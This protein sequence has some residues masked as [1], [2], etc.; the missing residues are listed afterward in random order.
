MSPTVP[1]RAQSGFSII[2]LIVALVLAASLFAALLLWFARPLEA[3]L[4]SQRQAAAAD[5]AERAMARFSAEIAGALPNSVRVACAGRCLELIPVVDAADYRVAS[6]GNTLDFGSADGEFDVLMPLSAAPA[7]G[8]Q[9]V[10]NNLN[11]GSTGNLSAYSA[12]ADNNRSS[13]VAGGSAAQIHIA[14]KQ[15]P[16]PSPT[17]RF[18]IVATPV[19]YVCDPA[20]SGGT[21]RRYAG[22]AI[23]PNQPVDTSLGD[24]LA[25]GVV[26]CRFDVV[27]E[28]LVA[29]RL[30]VNAGSGEAIA[31]F[32]QPR[33]VNLP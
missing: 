28:R 27:D 22:Y 25:D 23:Q 17:Q 30:H 18:Y 12:D 9:V 10:I 15:Y 4:E 29:W 8:L 20:P 31:M 14:P 13:V 21:V 19:S 32:A 24:L 6:P 3:L 7:A 11:A 5:H 2:E 26:D 1:A 33:I 16:L